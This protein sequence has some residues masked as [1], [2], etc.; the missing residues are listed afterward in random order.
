[1]SEI[2]KFC[3]EKDITLED[4]KLL[5]KELP[6]V[7]A[8]H[9][10]LKQKHLSNFKDSMTGIIKSGDILIDF[11]NEYLFKEKRRIMIHPYELLILRLLISNPHETIEDEEIMSLLQKY[12]HEVGYRSMVVYMSRLS[13]KVGLSPVGTKYVKRVWQ[14]GYCWN[15]YTKAD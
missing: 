6:K 14:E 9:L 12:G 13:K 10:D 2:D 4:L 8:R 1:M 5:S 11:S 7:R 15:Y 3:K